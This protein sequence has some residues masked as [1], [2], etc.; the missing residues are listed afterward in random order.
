MTQAEPFTIAI[1]DAAL[2]DLGARLENTRWI[3]DVYDADW[4]FGAPVP[5][6]RALCRHWLKV[7]DWRALETRLNVYDHAVTEIDGMRIHSMSQRSDR[8][9]AVPIMLIHGW[10]SSFVEFLDMVEPLTNPPPGEPAFHVVMPSLPGYGLSTVKPG[11]GPQT[12][13]SL[14]ARHMKALGYDKF[15][16]QGGDWGFLVGTEI[17]RQFPD[18]V[19]GL[20]LN[21]V[22]GSPPPDADIA[23]LQPHEQDWANDLG[24]WVS[25][26]HIVLHT[27]TP[28]SIAH[29]MNDS[30]AGLAAWIGEKMHQWI[31]SD[32][33]DEPFVAF[34]KLLA[35][36]AIYWFT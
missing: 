35:N 28:A 22:N 17:A 2:E 21:L 13:A 23:G 18:D 15:M 33:L 34:D 10:P 36:I 1:A 3:H 29:A 4:Q 20:H 26:P 32:G 27:Q 9:D 19:I 25:N 31:D 5:F 8:A 14:L 12:A 30:P 6:V 16:V 24:N 11:V 7:F